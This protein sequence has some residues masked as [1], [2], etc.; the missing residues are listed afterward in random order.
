M[1][2][3]IIAAMLW[4]AGLAPLTAQERHGHDPDGPVQSGAFPAGWS[5]RTDRGQPLEQVSFRPMGSGW[6]V[7][8]GPAVI[9]YRS[10]DTAR[11]QY[12][13]QAT[14]TQTRAPHHAEAYGLFVGGGDLQADGQ[15]YLYFLVRGDGKFL[16]KRRNGAE[17]SNVTAG[18]TAHDA[19]VPQDD[20]GKATNTLAVSV[21]DAEIV[22][23]VN[24]AAVY[25]V[26]RGDVVT[27]GI[28][29]LRVNHNL[30]LHIEGLTIE[31]PES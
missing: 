21:T 15:R 23:A 20:S 19:V 29:G 5:A 8:L 7:T 17:T 18:W 13:V 6:H 11:G 10:A 12:T 4:G 24:G 30:D 27:D 28:V 2:L 16:V 1:R 25:R 26:A 22:F 9:L 14:F 31:R 3:A